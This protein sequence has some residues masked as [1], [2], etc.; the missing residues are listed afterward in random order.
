MSSGELLLESDE[1][2]VVEYI[3]K[4]YT[5]ELLRNIC[6]NDITYG[7]TWQYGKASNAVWKNDP[8]LIKSFQLTHREELNQFA[9]NRIMNTCKD[10]IKYLPK[11]FTGVY[12]DVPLD[13]KELSSVYQGIENF[14]RQVGNRDAFTYERNISRGNYSDLSLIERLVMNVF[15]N[16][17]EKH[18]DLSIDPI[19]KRYGAKRNEVLNRSVYCNSSKIFKLLEKLVSD[20]FNVVGR[21][22]NCCPKHMIDNKNALNLLVTAISIFFHMRIPNSIHPNSLD[23]LYDKYIKRDGYNVDGIQFARQYSGCNELEI[24]TDDCELLNGLQ[25]IKDELNSS[26]VNIFTNEPIV[27]RTNTNDNGDNIIERYLVTKY[28]LCY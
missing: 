13:P 16:Y 11:L 23:R 18:Q 9:T 6:D 14:I 21:M 28:L 4:L 27:D 24:I 8:Q 15:N 1:G 5:I 12:S 7:L 26:Q 2:V 3:N 17:T 10:L 25:H 19:K 22:F 20:N